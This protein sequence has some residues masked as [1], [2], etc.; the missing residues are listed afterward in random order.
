V[1]RPRPKAQQDHVSQARQALDQRQRLR[2][3]PSQLLTQ[4]ARLDDHSRFVPGSEIHYNATDEH[5]I[6]LLEDCIHQ[7]GKPDQILTDQGTQFH[8]ARARALK[9]KARPLLVLGVF[10]GFSGIFLATT[11][12]AAFSWQ[13]SEN[14]SVNWLPYAL[15]FVAAVSWALYSNLSRRLAG[16]TEGGGVPVFLI[17]AGL[18]LAGLRMFSSERSGWTVKSLLELLYM[19]IFPA[20]FGYTF[21]DE[22]MRKGR[23]VLVASLS[24]FTPLLS[25][26]IAVLY[27]GVRTGWNLWAGSVLVVIGAAICKLSV[28]EGP[29]Q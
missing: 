4:C 13:T 14:V 11:Q 28:E 26:I 23:I 25:T 1:H 29:R 12:D 6:H 16:E 7:Y 21:W 27:L 9:R 24:Y 10:A 17:A 22:A 5:A 8:P 15:A 18:A 3:N 20:M 2:S 19:S